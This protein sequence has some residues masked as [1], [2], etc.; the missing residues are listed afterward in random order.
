[1]TKISIVDNATK[2]MCRECHK[3]IHQLEKK[4]V[5]AF[6]KVSHDRLPFHFPD[7]ATKFRAA[8]DNSEIW[9]YGG[10]VG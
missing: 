1:M 6:S 5:V 7:C 10:V 8:L 3:P 9:K 4:C 2:A